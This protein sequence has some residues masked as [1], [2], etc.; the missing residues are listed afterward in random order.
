LIR[1]RRGTGRFA[2]GRQGGGRQ[3]EGDDQTTGK[4]LLTGK[5]RNLVLRPRQSRAM[6]LK[7]VSGRPFSNAL[8]DPH[9]HS[10]S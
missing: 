1:V 7:G 4:L 2:P 10:R 3:G 6:R 9:P 5:T 8:E